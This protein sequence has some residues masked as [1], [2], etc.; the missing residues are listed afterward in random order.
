MF[1]FLLL[2]ELLLFLG[3]VL[4]DPDCSE[5]VKFADWEP[6]KSFD[7]NV[8]I[9][10]FICFLWIGFFYEI[11]LKSKEH[12]LI[13]KNDSIDEKQLDERETF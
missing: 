11:K 2:L 1:A 10:D 8:G 9:I 7:E 3:F 13:C 4:K 5:E 12:L 6:S